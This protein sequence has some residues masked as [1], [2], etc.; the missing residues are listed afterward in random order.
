MHGTALTAGQR[1]GWFEIGVEVVKP[2]GGRTGGRRV[3]FSS[4]GE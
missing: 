4:Q 3:A 1:G 2:S